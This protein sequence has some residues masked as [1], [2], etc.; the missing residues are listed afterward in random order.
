MWD[1]ILSS[2]RY[3]ICDC[4]YIYW[5]GFKPQGIRCWFSGSLWE[6]W[7][8]ETLGPRILIV[9]RCLTKYNDWDWLDLLVVELPHMCI[10][11]ELSQHRGLLEYRHGS[12]GCCKWTTTSRHDL[13]WQLDCESLRRIES[14][15]SFLSYS[16]FWLEVY[17][18]ALAVDWGI[19]FHYE[20]N[21][22]DALRLKAC[23]MY[24]VTIARRSNDAW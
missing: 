24:V 3:F 21:V 20:G 16:F 1:H 22:T 2:V 10:L 18:G 13:E 7:E 5:A 17:F 4:V 11:G 23:P 9:G 6:K 8:R 14:T 15:L 12:V 19:L